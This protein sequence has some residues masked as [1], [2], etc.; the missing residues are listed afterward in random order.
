MPSII[1]FPAN[2][3]RGVFAG[4]LIL[5]CAV[6]AGAQTTNEDSPDDAAPWN[7]KIR[8]HDPSTIVK[9][10]NTFWV[11]NTGVGLI[12]H[13]STDLVHWKSGPGIFANAPSW[14]AEAVPANRNRNFWAPDIMK[15]GHRWFMYYSISTWG[16]NVSAIGV[17]EN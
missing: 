9:D 2:R 13:Y 16:K 5:A 3:C 1:D 15:V 12:S 17:L 7:R 11:Y 4:M 10:G 6:T 14:A 8:V